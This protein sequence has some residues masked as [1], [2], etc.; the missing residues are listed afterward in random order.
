MGFVVRVKGLGFGVWG[1]GCEVGDLGFR[2][3]GSGFRL[4]SGVEF[5]PAWRT[6]RYEADLVESRVVRSCMAHIRQLRPESGLG[7]Q[8][9]VIKTA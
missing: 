2:L 6:A 7:L 8:V 5:T 3:Q 4:R 9:K 1:L